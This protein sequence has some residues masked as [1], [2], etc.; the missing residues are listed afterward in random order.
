MQRSP[1]VFLNM[2]TDKRSFFR[3]D[4]MLPCNYHILSTEEE[5]DTPLPSDLDSSYI[6][7][8]FLEDL[9][10]LDKQINDIISQIGQKSHL[11]ATALT[12]I[13]S[14]IDFVLQTV[15]E[16]H[17]SQTIPQ[18]MVNVSA[19][20]I[21][22]SVKES[23][24]KTDVLDILIQPL[25]DQSPILLRCKI[26]NIFPKNTLLGNHSN[27]SLEFQKISEENRRKLINFTQQKEIEFA[28]LAKEQE[29][30]KLSFK[31][32]AT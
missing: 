22:F 18:R 30:D 4:V 5:K 11:M 27:V 29:Q 25:K 7:R 15:D 23:L 12:A 19:S 8:F 10:E 28:Q 24:K 6:E 14:K 21:S 9:A 13:N 2:S 20:G 1:K 31:I 26:V 32:N 17:L 3:I 16:K